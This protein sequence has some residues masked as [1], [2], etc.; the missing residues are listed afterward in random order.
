MPSSVLPIRIRGGVVGGKVEKN[1]GRDQRKGR[2][3]KRERN[4]SVS[5]SPLY[6]FTFK[7]R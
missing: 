1:R 6:S 7:K 3:G 4:F 5:F 2:G